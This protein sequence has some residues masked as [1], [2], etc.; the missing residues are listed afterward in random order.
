MA[1]PVARLSVKPDVV[2]RIRGGRDEY[3]APP[4]C[5]GGH[6]AH[7]TFV[8]CVDSLGGHRVPDMYRIPPK[9]AAAVKLVPGFYVT[10]AAGDE[11]EPHVRVRATLF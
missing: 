10:L 6:P 7:I 1:V 3:P 8:R 11:F 2:Y 5:R 4:P 9:V